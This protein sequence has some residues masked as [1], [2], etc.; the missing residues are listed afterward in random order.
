[1]IDKNLKSNLIKFNVTKNEIFQ[2][3]EHYKTVNRKLK[4]QHTV[5]L[6]VSSCYFHPIQNDFF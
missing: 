3:N 1:M 6:L 5:E 2:L 4:M